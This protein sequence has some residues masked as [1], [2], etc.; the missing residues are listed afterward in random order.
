MLKKYWNYISNKHITNE[1]NKLEVIQAKVV[2]QFTFLISVFFI[3]D[4]L[5]DW[6]FGL[7]I[8]FY[9]LFT[10]GCLLFLSFFFEKNIR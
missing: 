4:S 2:N 3:I 10:I 8:N 1:M 7:L 5:R 6:T 9:I